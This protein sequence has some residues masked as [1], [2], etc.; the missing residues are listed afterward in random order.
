MVKDI[1]GGFGGHVLSPLSVFDSG[2]LE[3]AFYLLVR[4]KGCFS[5]HVPQPIMV[6]FSITGC[7][8]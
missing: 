7:Q 3:V 6:A 4:F 5:L 2:L 8:P 1:F